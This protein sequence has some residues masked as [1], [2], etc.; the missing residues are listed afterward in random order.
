MNTIRAIEDWALQAYVDGELDVP[1]R[2]AVENLLAADPAV[3][4]TVEAY[5]RQNAALRDAFA[6]VLDEPVPKAL[7]A[8][9]RRRPPTTVASWMQM[10]AAIGLLVI[11]GTSGWFADQATG[12]G[13]GLTLADNA[14]AAHEIYSPEV[15]HPVEV[16]GDQ[17]DQLQ[18]WLNK[19]I[20]VAF[21][22]P[23]LTDQ[24][25]TLLGGRLLAAGDKPA[26][27][28][29]YE[30]AEKKRITI[31][32]AANPVKSDAALQVDQKGPLIACYWLD[33]PLGFVVAGEMAKDRM[34]KLARIIYDKFEA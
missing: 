19:R 18:A 7:L 15:K 31:Y 2:D 32:L 11:G 33:G 3:R 24:G 29:M 23:D 21:K 8:A 22:V 25:Y 27:Q 5:T 20:G 6:S 26:A 34:M 4:A 16:A 9:A 1:D 28:L 13:P 12:P 17:R 30:D 14:I 10:A